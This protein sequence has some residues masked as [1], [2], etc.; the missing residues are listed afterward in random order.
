MPCFCMISVLMSIKP[1]VLLIS[2]DFFSVQLMNSARRPVKSR[3]IVV[4]SQLPL[5][6][7]EEVGDPR[8]ERVHVVRGVE[9]VQRAERPIPEWS[10]WPR[11]RADVRV[12][13][14]VIVVA[15]RHSVVQLLVGD[16]HVEVL[17]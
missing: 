1:W 12:R 15:G 10:G 3:S 13:R 4:T 2:G 9:R 14:R 8:R 5:A 16:R 6:A 17:R 7:L 11:P